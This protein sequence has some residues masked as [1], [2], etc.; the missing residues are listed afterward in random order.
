MIHL[1][2]VSKTYGSITALHPVTMEFGKGVTAL[3][4]ASGCGKSTLLRL[5]AGLIDPTTGTIEIDGKL[6][7]K[8]TVI[9]MRRQMGYVIQEGGLFP[10]LSARQNV[11]LMGS[12]LKVEKQA[13]EARITELANLVHLPTELLDRYP[14]ELSGGQRQRVS[15]MRALA[16]DPQILLLDEPLGALDPLVRAALQKDLRDLFAGLD[17][18]VIMVTHDLAEAAHLAPND[19]VLMREG[20]IVQRGPFKELVE[21]PT[22]PYVTEFIAA[23]RSLASAV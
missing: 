8:D 21:N 12:K 14:A 9:E 3:I 6:L 7:A 19:I 13:R 10:H 18:N 4:G 23:Q 20:S 22:D 16:L 5:I 11:D 2:D 17:K 1:R 15:L